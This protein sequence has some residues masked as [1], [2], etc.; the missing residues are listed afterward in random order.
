MPVSDRIIDESLR[1]AFLQYE[2]GALVKEIGGNFSRDT[3]F[4]L[5][6]SRLVG[7]IPAETEEL[8]TLMRRH[9]F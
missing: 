3:K 1:R 6:H 7:D 9:S 4:S 5:N 8:V 2:F